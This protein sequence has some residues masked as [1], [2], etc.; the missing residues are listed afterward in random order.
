LL[1][2]SSVIIGFPANLAQAACTLNRI[3]GPWNFGNM[4]L[5]Q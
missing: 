1:A 5:K 2:K 3:T 4:L